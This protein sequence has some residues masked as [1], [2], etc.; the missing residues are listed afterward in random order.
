MA[1]VD[2]LVAHATPTPVHARA[3]APLREPSFRAVWIAGLVSNIGTWLQNVAASWLVTELSASSRTITLL[4]AAAG[5]PAL[6]AYPAAVF[7]DMTD[8]RRILLIAESWMLVSVTVLSVL[9]LLDHVSAM[10]LLAC[11]FALGLG[12]AATMPT[13]Q[14]IIPSLVKRDELRD[15][16]TLNGM[17]VNLAR[18]IGPA[19]GGWLAATAGVGVGFLVNAVTLVYASIVLLRLR[20]APPSPAEHVSFRH[21]ASDGLVVALTSRALR[22]TLLRIAVFSGLAAALWALMPLLARRIAGASSQGF[23]ILYAAL[24]IGA[25]AGAMVV[26]FARA[27]LSSRGLLAGSVGLLGASFFGFAHAPN[28]TVAAAVLF[29]AGIAWITIMSTLI[30]AVQ[31]ASPEAYRSRVMGLYVVCFQ[32]GMGLSSIAWGWLVEQIGLSATMS[33][34]G[35]GLILGIALA[36]RWSIAPEHTKMGRDEDLSRSSALASPAAPSVPSSGIGAFRERR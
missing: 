22:G 26:P 23:G 10:S 32:G 9:T 30:V 29:V 33:G 28:V 1:F 21:A 19:I 8:R 5:V 24:G 15:A 36:S 12:G 34:A 14:A 4:Q 3:W 17:S 31:E 7:A 2:G 20:I 6:L 35:A 18:A 27:R 13:W 16:V 11:T 25:F